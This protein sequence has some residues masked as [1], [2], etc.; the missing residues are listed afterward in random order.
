MNE[1]SSEHIQQRINDAMGVRPD[2]DASRRR[3]RLRI[4][5]AATEHFLR[6]GYRKASVSD[7]AT[8]AGVAKGTVYLYFKSKNALMIAAIGYEKVQQISAF[9]AV[10]AKPPHEQLRAYLTLVGNAVK[11]S[12]LVARLTRGDREMKAVLDESGETLGRDHSAERDA[13][14]GHLIRNV[15]PSISDSD[16]HKRVVVL[17]AI[18]MMTAQLEEPDLLQD[19]TV[20]EF[21]ETLADILVSGLAERTSS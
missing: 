15:N 5:Q 12:P 21:S 16:L 11:D 3:T 17:N 2:E 13:F 6:F 7:I 1:W 10:M 18:I 19:Q 9:G 8:D 14:L 4:L 20:G